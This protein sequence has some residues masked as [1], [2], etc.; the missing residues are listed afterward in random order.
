ME[1]VVA[2]LNETGAQEIR[3]RLAQDIQVFRSRVCKGDPIYSNLQFATR[4]QNVLIT[5]ILSNLVDLLAVQSNGEMRY[6][7]A[8]PSATERSLRELLDRLGG[9]NAGGRDYD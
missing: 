8:P 2:R 4:S 5:G 7:A 9:S 1:Q 3:T 6:G